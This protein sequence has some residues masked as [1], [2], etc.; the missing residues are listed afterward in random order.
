[1]SAAKILFEAY[2]DSV[3]SSL[4]AQEGKADGIELCA[5]LLE[6]GTANI[7]EYELMFTSSKKI[8]A[9]KETIK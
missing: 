3:E 8:R 4:A 9:I 2:V 1:M 7:P 5:D 6:G